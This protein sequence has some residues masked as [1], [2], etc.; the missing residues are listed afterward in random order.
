MLMLTESVN[1]SLL[2]KKKGNSNLQ[3]V[4]KLH[5]VDLESVAFC[6]ISS[7]MIEP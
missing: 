3:H 7:H 2:K 1:L 5:E 4:F 6:L